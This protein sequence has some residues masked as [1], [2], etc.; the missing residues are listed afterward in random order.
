MRTFIDLF[1][2]IGGF[3]LSLEKKRL[4]CVYSCELDKHAAWAYE[5]NFKENP[6]GDIRLIDEA[7]IPPH[8]VLCAGFPCQSFSLAGKRKGL[9]DSRGNLFYE[10]V[11]IAKHRKPSVILLENVKNILTINESSVFNQLKKSLENIGYDFYHSVLNCSH[12]G[13]PQNRCRV[14]IV[15]LRRGSHLR[16]KA[17]EPTYKRKYLKEILLP[18]EKCK[19]LI[20]LKRKYVLY[21]YPDTNPVLAPIRIGHYLIPNSKSKK[22]FHGMR[23]YSANGHAITLCANSGGLGGKT[24]YYLVNDV[25]RKLHIE[26][27]KRLMG[28]PAK[29]IVSQGQQGYRQFGNAVCAPMI[30]RIFEGIVK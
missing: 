29:H 19:D 22:A 5:Q 15:C 7:D 30:E 14:Y 2:G 1:C 9:E 11:R 21:S 18:N 13:I 27:C 16:Y 6:L 20:L 28:F 17:P 4:K 25:V 10:I 12:F 26:E 23:I 3:R 8:D 24:G